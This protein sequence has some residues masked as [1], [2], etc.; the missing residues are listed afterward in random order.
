M[1]FSSLILL[2]LIKSILMI[3][4]VG[5]EACDLNIKSCKKDYLELLEQDVPFMESKISLKSGILL[6]N[7]EFIVERINNELMKEYEKLLTKI[8]NSTSYM[9]NIPVDQRIS[10]YLKNANFLSGEELKRG[11]MQI[12]KN[13]S[14]QLNGFNSNISLTNRVLHSEV[15]DSEEAF[16]GNG[17]FNLI[18]YPDEII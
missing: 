12:L 9:K 6:G 3:I 8:Q 16:L 18:L 14:K 4:A 13:Y 10:E 5:C 1:K 17:F 2:F 7:I 15:L 11:I